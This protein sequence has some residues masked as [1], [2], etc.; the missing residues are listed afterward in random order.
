MLYSTKYGNN[1]NSSINSNIKEQQYLCWT[2][3]QSSTDENTL[4]DPQCANWVKQGHIQCINNY[5][6]FSL[7]VKAA[8]LIFISGCG[9]AI[10]SAKE[11]ILGFIYYLV[12][13]ILTVPM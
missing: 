6:D 9:S 5:L 8:T 12:S 10:S 3:L 4:F 2:V 1:I 13:P 11:G 7:T